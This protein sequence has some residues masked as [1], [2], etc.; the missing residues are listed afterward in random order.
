M[1]SNKIMKMIVVLMSI[2]IILLNFNVESYAITKEEME[3]IVKTVTNRL[4]SSAPGGTGGGGG[5]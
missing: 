2:C 4:Y 1:K 5:R 3:N